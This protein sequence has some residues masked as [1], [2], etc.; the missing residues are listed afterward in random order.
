[1]L[2][3]HRNQG[4]GDPSLDLR[5][6]TTRG[7]GG[8]R[9]E[10]RVRRGG[11]WVGQ[12]AGSPGERRSGALD[13]VGPPPWFP[14]RGEREWGREETLVW[15]E[16]GGGALPPPWTSNNPH[17]RALLPPPTPTATV[18][19]GERSHIP[20]QTVKKLLEAQRR[21]RQSGTNYQPQGQVPA[22]SANETEP[23]EPEN[24]ESNPFS[25]PPHPQHPGSQP[26]GPESLSVPDPSYP[27]G[28]GS[29]P[30]APEVQV[31]GLGAPSAPPAQ[32]PG[33]DL[34][35]HVLYPDC[36]YHCAASTEAFFTPGLFT[37]T[38]PGGLPSFPSLLEVRPPEHGDGGRRR[39][40]ESLD[41]ARAE[42]HALGLQRLLA[43]DEEGDTLLHLF[44]AQG[45][46]WSA[47][48]AAEVL[49]GCGQLDIR[50]HQGKT[51]LLVAASANQPL[52]VQDLLTLGADPNATDHRGRTILHL[53]ATYG[54]PG[55]LTAVFNSGIQV[56]M[57]TRDFE[58]LTPLH[59]A[60]LSL[61]EATQQPACSSRTMTVP[62]RDRLACVQMLLQ[63]G[64]DHTS[65]EF[66]SNKTVLHLAVQGGNLSL[67]QM[68][69]DLPNG[70][71]RA[72]VNM[73]AHGNTALHMA[74]ALPPGF[75]QEPIIRGLLA[76]GAD[77]ALRNLENE[78]PAHLLGPGPASEALRQLL[79]RS[80]TLPLASSS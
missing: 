47:Y 72:F 71:P 27:A 41:T 59:A 21:R 50:E 58:G 13:K 55:V 61:N 8:T 63:M 12:M 42:V 49:Q 68:L 31:A 79:K 46:R 25:S 44:A 66:K 67:V 69:L 22:T 14:R 28:L 52:I 56:D 5:E 77:P 9:A 33:W 45:L 29:F 80:R 70:D 7:G 39:G 16:R 18:S 78:Q 57:E 76:A 35:A 43:Q 23:G 24:E 48:A 54:L 65:Q 73:K 34:E 26:R 60:V 38:E 4:L 37:A 15:E 40:E 64:A 11:M 62:A 17:P 51:P 19:R 30:G 53:A 74:A 36:H 2:G 32:A 20:S 10:A 6:R 75:P 1:M 3:C